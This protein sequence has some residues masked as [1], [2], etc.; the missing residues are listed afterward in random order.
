M[1][2]KYHYLSENLPG[3]KIFIFGLFYKNQQIGFQ[4]F[5]NYVPGKKI[6][7]FNRTVIHPDYCGFGLGMKLIDSTSKFVQE[8]GYKIM[9]KFSSVSIYKSMIK[10]SNW[11]LVA[12]G[13]NTPELTGNF[14]AS[15]CNAIR[16]K[17]KWWSFKFIG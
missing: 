15:K 4:C 7:H 10:N 1:F 17:V 11:V 16:T 5:A 6:M 12:T 2:S 13:H 3:G 14:S 9:G 8:K